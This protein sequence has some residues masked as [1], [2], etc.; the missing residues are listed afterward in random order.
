MAARWRSDGG[1]S[2]SSNELQPVTRTLRPYL[3]LHLQVD[4]EV[5]EQR[6]EDGQRELE[7]LRHGGDSVLGQRHAQVLLDGVH[8]HL[9]SPEHR[10]GALKHGEQQLQGH[11]LGP[12]LMGP[13]EEEEEEEREE[14][15]K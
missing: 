9:V 6:E 11:D 10:A 14:E 13:E 4:L 3:D 15:E 8:E 2:D 1:Q 7:D 5:G 12:Q